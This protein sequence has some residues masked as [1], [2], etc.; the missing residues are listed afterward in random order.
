MLTLRHIW[1]SMAQSSVKVGSRESAKAGGK[2]A[3]PLR[4][5]LSDP[6]FS[7][8]FFHYL[9]IPKNTPIDTPISYVMS[10][11]IGKIYRLWIEYPRGCSGLAGFQLHRAVRQIFPLPDGIW[12]R[13]DNSVMN[14]AFSHLISNEPYEVILKGYNLDDTYDHTIWVGFEMSGIVADL[15]P[16]MK[17]FIKTL[18]GG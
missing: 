7:I 16:E 9:T 4:A 3:A 14:F 5:D 2:S 6:G 1:L 11:P 12:L 13:S 10:L 17:A 18:Q 15:T 8:P